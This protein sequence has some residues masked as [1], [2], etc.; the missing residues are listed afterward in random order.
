MRDVIR[1]KCTALI[2]F[3]QDSD[4]LVYGEFI[5]VFAFSRLTSDVY[6]HNIDP[7]SFNLWCD[8][9]FLCETGQCFWSI[10]KHNFWEVCVEALTHTNEGNCVSEALTRINRGE[11][12]YEA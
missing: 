4:T 3:S 5:N 7:R 11:C 8:F 1:K 2:A 12:V 9:F 10:G 6:A